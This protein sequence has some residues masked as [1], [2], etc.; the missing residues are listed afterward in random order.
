MLV[1]S[2]GEEEKFVGRGTE[3]RTFLY[4]K[5]SAATLREFVPCNWQICPVGSGPAAGANLLTAFVDQMTSLDAEDKPLE[6]MRYVLFEIPVGSAGTGSSAWVLF[7]GLSTGGQGIYGTNLEATAQVERR[8]QHGPSG[9]EVK[10]SWNLEA[11]GEESVSLQLRFLRG[12]VSV[13]QVESRVYSQVRPQFSRIYRV[14][15]AVDVV[16]PTGE[17]GRL[18]QVA[19]K[20]KSAKLAPLFDGTEQLTAVVSVPAYARRIFLPSS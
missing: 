6:L 1:I 10:E 3:N 11:D 2:M 9:S 19:F 16:H 8:I 12:P 18:T 17:L 5:V 7:T 13:E 15:Q 20:A 14:E 4:F